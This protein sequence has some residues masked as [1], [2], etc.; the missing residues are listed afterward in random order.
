MPRYMIQVR[1]TAMSEAG[2]FPDDPTLVP[3]MMAFHDEMAKAGVLLDGAG[4]HGRGYGNPV[5]AAD[6]RRQLVAKAGR[7]LDL[8]D[9]L[10]KPRGLLE[11]HALA[12]AVARGGER[13][14]E[15]AAAALQEPGQPFD[16]APVLLRAHGGLARAEAHVHLA[17][18]AAGVTGRG[19]E[20]L[21]AAADLEQF[22]SGGLEHL[23]RRSRP[24]RT[25][26]E[27]PRAE[28]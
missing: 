22:E 24:E 2:D 17:V 1:A 18:D 12:E 5:Q 21:R 8:L 11:L 15:R 20:V 25:I 3:R 23:R 13:F 27:G 9:A 19:L 6:I 7:L 10:V 26:V 28:L 16:L 14:D 4:L